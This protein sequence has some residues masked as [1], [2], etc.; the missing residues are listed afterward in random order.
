MAHEINNPA[1][2]VLSNM[3]TMEEYSRRLLDELRTQERLAAAADDGDGW[4]ALEQHMAAFLEDEELQYIEED[5]AALLDETT[6]GAE[7]IR[8]IVCNLKTYAH[9]GDGVPR[10]VDVNQQLEQALALI[11][12]QL[13]YRSEVHTD[14]GSLPPVLGHGG[15]LGQAF[16]NLLV[17]ASQAVDSDG[18][19]RVST[20]ALKGDDAGVEIRISDN[21][22]GMDEE[23]QE[24]IFEPFFTTKEVGHGAGLGLSMVYSIVQRHEG[25]IDVHSARGEGTVFTIELPAARAAA[26]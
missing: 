3:E 12:N 10:E 16:I 2:F 20:R 19:I 9:P 15:E 24:H 21:G 4:A 23:V 6:A 8:G 17:N 26:A 25:T 1:G 7:R 5:C 18:Q 14:L 22:A 11:Q 13:R